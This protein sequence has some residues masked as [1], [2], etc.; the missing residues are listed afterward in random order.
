MGGTIDRVGADFIEVATHPAG[1]AR[2]RADV[3]DVELVTLA[4]IAAVRRSV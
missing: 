1:E 2:R 3:R 4:A